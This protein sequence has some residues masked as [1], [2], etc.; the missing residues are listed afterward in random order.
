MQQLDLEN[1]NWITLQFIWNNFDSFWELIKNNTAHFLSNFL[2]DNTESYYTHFLEFISHNKSW[3]SYHKITLDIF[4]EFISNNIDTSRG[5]V[6]GK[7]PP[8]NM[9]PGK[10]PPGKISPGK[11]PPENCPPGKLLPTPPKKSIL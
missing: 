8:G 2:S 5:T 6:L 11:L 4:G 10:M 9:P 1:N 3:A 7:M